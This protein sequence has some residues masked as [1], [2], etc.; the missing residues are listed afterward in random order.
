M[1]PPASAEDAAVRVEATR[2]GIAAM[3]VQ[4]HARG[5]QSRASRT[6]RISRAIKGLQP[7]APKPAGS[8]QRLASVVSR[9]RTLAAIE[10]RQKEWEAEVDR[11]TDFEEVKAALKESMKM[12][13]QRTS[14]ICSHGAHT[15]PHVT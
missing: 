14:Q 5:N 8:G 13:A 4:R 11:M 3:D 12:K 10:A 15:Q 1:A 9:A 2:R 6:S 7:T